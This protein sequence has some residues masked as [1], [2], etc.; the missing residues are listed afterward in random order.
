[1]VKLKIKYFLFTIMLMNL[2]TKAQDKPYSN[3][4]VFASDT[5]APLWI[6]KVFLKSD[7][8]TKATELVFKDIIRIKPLAFFLLGDVVSLGY[9]ENKWRPVD[10]YIRAVRD[11]G[12]PIYAVLGNHELMQRPVS[13]EAKFQIRFPDH[14]RTGYLQMFDSIAVVLL[15]SNF[16]SLSAEEIK[17]Q[18]KWLKDTVEAL[19]SNEAVNAIIFGCHHPPYTNSRLVRSSALVQNYFVEPFLKSKKA[20]L[21]ITGHSHA[22][23]YF[24]KQGK[25]FIIIG[26][27]G[28]LN[29]PL[30][31]SADRLEDV[32]DKYKPHF[33][34]LTVEILNDELVI[35]SHELQGSP[36]KSFEIGYSIKIPLTEKGN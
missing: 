23:E 34:Y 7:N 29:H 25:D 10:A 30:S 11:E 18:N 2:V 14:K 12:I 35:V 5:Q 33:H 17:Q 28:G 3:M 24:K 26:G 22:F 8:N 1:M 36:F 9:S 32:S 19:D 15:N 6:E 31:N 4:L 13:G 20:K 21:F 16:N 27:G